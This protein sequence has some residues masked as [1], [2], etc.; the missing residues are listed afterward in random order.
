M[1]FF[2][3]GE[4]LVVARITGPSH[5]LLQVLLSSVQEVGPTEVAC[6]QLAS[7]KPGAP[8]R[9]N[10]ALITS[11]V[12]QGVAEANSSFG[13]NYALV[14]LRYVADDSPPESVY[15]ELAFRVVERLASGGEFLAQGG[16]HAA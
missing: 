5:N 14:R 7:V 15:R 2:R 10:E 16:A 4:Y 1:Q 8:V 13:T 6:L 12:L 9:L 3:V 11:A